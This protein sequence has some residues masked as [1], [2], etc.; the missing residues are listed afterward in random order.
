ML[1]TTNYT[2]SDKE[3][4]DVALSLAVGTTPYGAVLATCEWL[5]S[6]LAYEPGTTKVSSSAI[7][8]FKQ[9]GG[10]CQDFAHIGIVMM[11]NLGIPVRYVSGYLHPQYDAPIGET[12]SGAS[13]AW[14]EV[15]LDGWIPFDPTNGAPVE[16]RHVTVAHGRDYGDVSPLRGVYHGGSLEDLQVSVDLTRLS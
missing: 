8:A 1:T 2:P 6:N 9:R 3:I 11:R 7:E 5:H 14:I 15:W 13:H 4:A 16:E 12:V 10:V